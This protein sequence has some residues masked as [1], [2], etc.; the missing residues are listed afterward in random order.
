MKSIAASKKSLLS[1]RVVLM[2]EKFENLQSVSA[3]LGNF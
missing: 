2:E 1:I 3:D